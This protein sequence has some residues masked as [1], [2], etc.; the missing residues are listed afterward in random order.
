MLLSTVLQQ[1]SSELKMPHRMYKLQREEPSRIFVGG[2]PAAS[3]MGAADHRARLAAAGKMPEWTLA[4]E[5]ASSFPMLADAFDSEAMLKCPLC[6]GTGCSRDFPA[7]P[8]SVCHGH[9]SK[10][11][12]SLVK[13]P[14]AD[15]EL[16]EHLKQQTAAY[17][18]DQGRWLTSGI[19][20]DEPR[21]VGRLPELD[22][23]HFMVKGTDEG[24]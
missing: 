21:L 16:A 14:Q 17:L 8:C 11:G 13:L 24:K 15:E 22:L 4:D 12:Y 6:I 18:R 3:S 9:G 2:D 20:F 19:R 7:L 5:C 10:D 1:V 23:T